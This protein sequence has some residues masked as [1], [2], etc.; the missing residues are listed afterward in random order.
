MAARMRASAC[1]RAPWFSL[2]VFLRLPLD[3]AGD[4]ESQERSLPHKH[5]SQLNFTLFSSSLAVP[6]LPHLSTRRLQP[7]IF[8]YYYF[9][10]RGACVVQ[11][12]ELLTE[13]LTSSCTSSGLRLR[14]HSK[15]KI[16]DDFERNLSK[17][18]IPTA[19]DKRYNQRS[20]SLRKA[21]AKQEHLVRL[22]DS[23]SI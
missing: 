23:V 4:R 15:K 1:E 2:S 22:L 10:E 16:V 9:G 6:L 18:T 7:C 13:L 11:Y 8:F 3:M 21:I 5:L 14:D 20:A 12:K 19:M 17:L